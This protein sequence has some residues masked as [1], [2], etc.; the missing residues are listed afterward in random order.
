MTRLGMVVL[1]LVATAAAIAV[2]VGVATGPSQQA[3]SAE[4]TPAQVA[5]LHGTQA[6]AKVRAPARPAGDDEDGGGKWLPQDG[7][8]EDGPGS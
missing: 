3:V 7:D 5:E 6:P 1:G 2:A 4:L 8:G